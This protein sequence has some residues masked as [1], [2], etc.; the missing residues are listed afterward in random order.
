MFDAF[1]GARR[2]EVA[3]RAACPAAGLTRRRRESFVGITGACSTSLAGAPDANTIGLHNRAIE[4][5]L[6]ERQA[7]SASPPVPEKISRPTSCCI[8]IAA[9]SR[10]APGLR[11][12]AAAP[13]S[14]VTVLN[15]A[16]GVR[17]RVGRPSSS[18][19]SSAQRHSGQLKS[20]GPARAPVRQSRRR[21]GR[22]LRSA[23]QRRVHAEPVAADDLRRRDDHIS[24]TPNC[25]C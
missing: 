23:G 14:Q 15:V 25:Q 22:R 21:Q 24:P 1:A 9:P 4:S 12:A 18:Q 5:G 10:H 3:V 6:L 8:G 13:A 20:V 11:H 17:C 2:A 7:D 19:A 16:G